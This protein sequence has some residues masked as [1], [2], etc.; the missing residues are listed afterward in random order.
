MKLKEVYNSSPELLAKE[1]TGGKFIFRPFQT[2]IS[3]IIV[4][5]II[6]GNGRI[7]LSVPPQ[8]GKSEVASHWALVWFLS[9]FPEKHIMLLSYNEKY[10]QGWGRVTRNTVRENKEKLFVELSNDSTAAGYWHTS[11]G[12]SMMCSGVDGTMT[13]RPGHVIIIDDPHKNWVEAMSE[14][15]R[16]KVI[17]WYTK[18]VTQRFQ[19]DTTV[20]VIQTRWHKQD[21][22][23]YLLKHGVDKW[24]EIRLPALAEKNDPLGRKE[25]EPL[26]PQKYSKATLEKRK[27]ES[28]A[29]A[30]AAI[31]QQSPQVQDGNIFKREWWQRYDSEGKP[32]RFTRIVCSWDTA[33]ETKKNSSY[34]ACTVWGE[35]DKKYYLLY[36]WRKKAEYPV[37]KNKIIEIMKRF[38]AAVCLLEDKAS[39]KSLRQEL[40]PAGVSVIPV[41]PL[42]DKLTR[43]HSVTPMFENAGVF[44]PK[45]EEWADDIIAGCAEY[46]NGDFSDVVD[47][48]SQALAWMTQNRAYTERELD[49]LLK[50]EYD[51]VFVCPKHRIR[52]TPRFTRDIFR[53]GRNFYE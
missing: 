29:M 30:F 34:N 22:A 31:Y 2:Y 12:G 41:T 48:L 38:S 45:G 16:N 15:K 3:E 11:A 4:N 28:G 17:E 19:E 18:T 21:L 47:T 44:I 9:N 51:G 8:H 53:F 50:D 32:K 26:A 39:G 23:G 27:A 1:C 37:I 33:F 43:A 40:V 6:K 52:Q 36:M 14:T 49:V 20:I 5:A 24:Q 35:K 25:G 7:I 42:A 13:G 46:P 10:A